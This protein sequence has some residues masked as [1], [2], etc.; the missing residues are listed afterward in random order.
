M[1]DGRCDVYSTL[2]VWEHLDVRDG[3]ATTYDQFMLNV[4]QAIT[5]GH[6]SKR[7]IS[8]FPA[9]WPGQNISSISSFDL[10]ET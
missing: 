2:D 7:H 4:R 3:R 1:E 8:P 6:I 5:D 10:S 9:T